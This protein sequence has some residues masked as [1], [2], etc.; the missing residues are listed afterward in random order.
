MGNYMSRFSI[1]KDNIIT[2]DNTVEKKS[3]NLL[4]SKHIKENDQC[5]KKI[6]NFNNNNIIN[7]Y[8][9]LPIPMNLY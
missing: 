2:S 8:P 6:R 3:K 9:H 4:S 5:L 1:R 7:P